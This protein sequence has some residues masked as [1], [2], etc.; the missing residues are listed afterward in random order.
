MS[1]SHE[2]S[3]LIPAQ[4]SQPNSVNLHRR[5]PCRQDALGSVGSFDRATHHWQVLKRIAPLHPYPHFLPN[6]DWNRERKCLCVASEAGWKIVVKTDFHQKTT[7][8]WLWQIFV[9]EQR[10]ERKNC[11][12]QRALLTF[13]PMRRMDF[14]ASKWLFLD[15]HL[16]H[17]AQNKSTFLPKWNLLTT[18]GGFSPFGMEY[19]EILG[20]WLFPSSE[21]HPRKKQP[22]SSFWW[23]KI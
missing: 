7:P 6:P 16:L 2:G 8:C 19:A 5:S 21:W 20:Y 13:S 15:I 9:Q 4:T 23:V 11:K 10:G 18:L 17:S 3:A 12:C 1:I 14:L 22:F